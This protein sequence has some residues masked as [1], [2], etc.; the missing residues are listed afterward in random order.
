MV[1]NQVADDE[2]VL[3][4]IPGGV[5]FQAPPGGRIMSKNF[6][7]RIDRG[8]T[9]ISVSRAAITRPDQLMARIGNSTNGSRIA[10]ATATDIRALGLDVVPDPKDYDPGHAE[11]RSAAASLESQPVRK[12]LAR[13]FQFVA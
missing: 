5:T 9:G 2:A 7:L 11:I 8:E 13:L 1:A 6:E 12:A 10:C 3:R 4:H